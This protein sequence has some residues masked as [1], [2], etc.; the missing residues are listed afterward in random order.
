LAL[1]QSI[2]SDPIDD[3]RGHVRSAKRAAAILKAF[4]FEDGL[5]GVNELGRRLG[6]LPSTV[7]RLASTLEAEG[8]LE[9]DK[10][11]GKYRL[12]LEMLRL[13]R[14]ALTQRGIEEGAISWMR[15]L[16]EKT[17]EAVVLSTLVDGQVLYLERVES[18]HVLRTDVRVGRTM[19]AHCTAS[20]KMLLALLPCEEVERIVSRRGLSSLTPNTISSEP[21]LKEELRRIREQGYSIDDEEQAPG[22]RCIG[23]AIFDHRGRPAAGIAVSGPAGRLSM[24]RLLDIKSDLLSTAESISRRLGWFPTAE[25]YIRAQA[26]VASEA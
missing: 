12:G 2:G 3:E 15:E 6:L 8:L 17:D 18:R 21:G 23:T 9:Q 24:E 1:R 14:V 5:L 26:H 7:Y 13:G 19:P 25:D 20:G 16:A 11:S 10:E 22:V 4:T